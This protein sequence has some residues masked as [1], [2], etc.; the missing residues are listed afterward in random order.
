MGAGCFA[1][2]GHN[3]VGPAR[4]DAQGTRDKGET[5]SRRQA[6]NRSCTDVLFLLAYLAFFG[7][8]IH[9]G[10]RAFRNGHWGRLA[11]GTDSFGNVCGTKGGPG[12]LDLTH[13][14]KLVYADATEEI[15]GV[16]LGRRLRVCAAECPKPIVLC[17]ANEFPCTSNSNF[18]CPYYKDGM[19]FGGMP[20]L[21]NVSTR[22]FDQLENSI[23]SECATQAARVRSWREAGLLGVLPSDLSDALEASSES[24][25]QCGRLLR[26][27]SQIHG[28]GPCFPLIHNTTNVMNRCL[29]N[30]P[31]QDAGPLLPDALAN[32]TVWSFASTPA[33]DFGGP[34]ETTIDLHDVLGYGQMRIYMSDVVRGWSIL[35]VAGIILGTLVSVLASV[36]LRCAP[37]PVLATTTALANGILIAAALYCYG[38]GGIISARKAIG[39][40]LQ[41]Y[42]AIDGVVIAPAE[43]EAWR[44]LAYVLSGFFAVAFLVTRMLKE[45]ASLRALR[46]F[47]AGTD[48]ILA[49]P[50]VVVFPLY[51]L[52]GLIV[53]LGWWIAVLAF[54]WSSGELEL[55]G[56]EDAAEG[57]LPVVGAS[58][59]MKWDTALTIIMTYHL[60]GLLWTLNLVSGLGYVTVAHAV[61]QYY[62]SGGEVD[63]MARKPMQR[64]CVDVLRFHLG[65]VALGSLITTMIQPFRMPLVYAMHKTKGRLDRGIYRYVLCFCGCI[66]WYFEKIAESANACAYVGVAVTGKGYAASAL[67]VRRL[68]WAAP[69]DALA[70]LPALSEMVVWLATLGIGALCGLAAFLMTNV[71]NYT[72][73]ASASFLSSQI[74]PTIVS[75]F[76][77]FWIAK[78]FMQAHQVATTTLIM[79]YLEDCAAAGGVGGVSAGGMPRALAVALGE[80]TGDGGATKVQDLGGAL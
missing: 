66:M 8:W 71:T 10:V 75:G 40:D 21:P 73:P 15:A 67:G 45:R 37:A 33:P 32:G 60:F 27:T 9:F 5:V 17:E 31:A 16:P 69:D 26:S 55:T 57:T 47:R 51:A 39:T 59:A 77:G 4:D 62:R 24:P 43:T 36:G 76:A 63:A 22:Y 74:M 52:A 65:T 14:K 29:P 11:Y 61:H 3:R 64:A 2:G 48:A 44:V 49:I 56:G 79:C 20:A 72:D 1:G 28:A 30:E 18:V 50:S 46:L 7:V 6:L 42:N 58:Y 80:G 23:Q 78:L 12:G 13:A 34:N 68:L 53:F 19:A 41:V 54:L 35:L 70:A 25:A 38:K